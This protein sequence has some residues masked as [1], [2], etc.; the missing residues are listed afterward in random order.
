MRRVKVWGGHIGRFPQLIAGMLAAVIVTVLVWH[1]HARFWWPPDD[2]AYAYVAQRI[3]HGAV[4]NRDIHDIHGGYVHFIHAAAMRLF[5]E[6]IVSL[7]YPLALLTV[8]QSALVYLLLLPRGTYVA[9][10]G[11]VACAAFS[12]IQF[13]N[14]S[15]NWYV[16]P[17]AISIIAVLTWTKPGSR[18]RLPT[19]GFLLVTALLLRQLSGVFLI[20]GTITWLL[21]ADEGHGDSS[22]RLAKAVLAVFGAL[23]VAYLWS[24]QSVGAVLLFGIWP[25]GAL[26]YA[27]RHVR[28]TD[29]AAIRLCAGLAL[30]GIVASVPLLVYHMATGSVSAWLADTVLDPK[31]HVAIG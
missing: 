23:I 1:F 22:P 6:D 8:A 18:L 15:A 7:R 14:P 13:L 25:L 24:K 17:V 27:W 28:V 19:I 16:P 21:L 2:G 4:L 9:F 20:I 29:V 11:T 12:F 31:D 10:A 30:G 3:L 26:L 5:G